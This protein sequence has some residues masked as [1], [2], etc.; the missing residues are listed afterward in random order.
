MDEN[1]RR[2]T[3][4]ATRPSK[5]AQGLLRLRNHRPRPDSIAYATRDPQGSLSDS[6]LLPFVCQ[7]IDEVGLPREEEPEAP[8]E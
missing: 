1:R 2:G 4:I 6:L 7:Q 8:P 5:M 3:V